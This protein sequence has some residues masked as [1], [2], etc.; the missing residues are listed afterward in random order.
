[1]GPTSVA[2]VPSVPFRKKRF[3]LI[4]PGILLIAPPRMTFNRF[5]PIITLLALGFAGA[6]SAMNPYG[7][8]D[9]S[10]AAAPKTLPVMEA[11]SSLKMQAVSSTESKASAAPVAGTASSDGFSSQAALP[12]LSESA[13]TPPLNMIAQV[14]SVLAVTGFT[15]GV[16]MTLRKPPV[17]RN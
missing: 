16:L 7:M 5:A 4:L 1:M 15:A 10:D 3:S 11:Q 14:I 6:A 13:P 8:Q 2:S 9:A 17:P 12:Q